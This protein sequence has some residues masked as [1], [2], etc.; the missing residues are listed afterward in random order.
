M[1]SILF[2]IC[3]QAYLFASGHIFVYHRFDDSRYPSANTSKQNLIK[4]FEYLKENN[5]KVVSLNE[6]YTKINLKQNIPDNWIA[7]T[8]DDAYKSFYTNALDIFKKYNYPFTL[9]VY[10]KATN[11]KYG[12]FMTWD[13]LNEAKKYG[14][15]GL[16][17]HTHPHLLDLTLDD[18]NNDTKIAYELFTKNMGFEPLYYAY[19]YGEYNIDIENELKKF[20]FHMILNQNTGSIDKSS[21]LNSINR[22]ALVGKSNI[23]TKLKYTTLKVQWLEPKE[24]P[25]DGI[26]KSVKAKVDKSIKNV[27]L[28]ITGNGWVDLKVKDGIIASKLNIKLTRSRTRITIGTD[29]YNVATHIIIKTKDKHDK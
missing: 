2:F 21:N 20:N 29:Y 5:Y 23:I 28:Y 1:K 15:I 3:F 24:F 22:V 16:H 18:V 19:P 6:I 11:S 10:T 25:K 13:M 27:K 26:L 8:I 7:F 14:E 9:F 12:D 4:Q 17:S